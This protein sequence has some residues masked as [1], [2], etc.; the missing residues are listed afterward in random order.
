[1]TIDALMPTL[2]ARTE[3]ARRYKIPAQGSR[4]V[5]E[6]IV[7]NFQ[8]TGRPLIGQMP[9]SSGQR[10]TA[11]DL[12]VSGPGQ[13]RVLAG[14]WGIELPHDYLSFCSAYSQYLF[15]G[16]ASYVVWDEVSIRH[17]VESLRSGWGV[18]SSTPLRL[19]PFAS[20]AGEPAYFAFRWS[21]TTSQMD[22]VYCWDY[23]DVGEEHL[24]GAEGEAFVSDASFTA[25]LQ[26]MIQSDGA[27]AFPGGNVPMASGM[28]EARQE[29]DWIQ[30]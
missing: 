12:A 15:V 28:I 17:Q 20:P 25:W 29:Q 4:G 6:P 5:I 10:M 26:R 1:M 22:V 13:Q 30:L 27:P 19:F 9:K 11:T 24:L 18:A 21:S 16:R 8:S 2:A 3:V 23:G 14:E 7:A